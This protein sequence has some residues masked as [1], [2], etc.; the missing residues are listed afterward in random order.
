MRHN[1]LMQVNRL[2]VEG[3]Q[4]GVAVN[5]NSQRGDSI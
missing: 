4:K 3:T 1:I 2:S 5:R